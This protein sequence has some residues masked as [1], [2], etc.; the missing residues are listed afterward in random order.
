[1]LYLA[2]T[3]SYAFVNHEKRPAQWISSSLKHVSSSRKFHIIHQ[4]SGNTFASTT[5]TTTKLFDSKKS[6][7]FEGNKGKEAMNLERNDKLNGISDKDI[8]E[9]YD[10]IIIGSGIGGLSAACLLT[11]YGYSVLVLESHYKPGGCAHAF[12]V[13]GFKFDAGPSLWNGMS[14]LP[15]N[16]L[17]EILNLV[18]EGDSISYAKYDGWQMY[19]PDGSFK[20]TVG[21]GDFEKILQNFGDSENVLTEWQQLLQLVKPYQDLADAVPPLCLRSDPLVI[22][23]LLP[24]LPKLIKGIPYASQIEKDFKSLSDRVVKDSFLN[25]WL[26]FLSFALSGLPADATITAAVVYTMRD[27]H[28]QRAA[29]DYP[30]GG[31]GAVVDALI[32]GMENK[33]Q[34][35][36]GSGNGN[37]KGQGRLLLNSHV[38]RILIEEEDSSSGIQWPWSTTTTTTT[39]S[40]PSDSGSS[41]GN[42]VVDRSRSSNSNSNSSSRRG[43]RKPLEA[44]GVELRKNKRKIYAKR[45]VI[46]NASYWDTMK[47]LPDICMSSG[48]LQEELDKVPRTNSFVHLHL[49]INGEGLQGLESHYTVINQWEKIDA[50]QNHVIISIPTV[51]D[52]SLAPPGCHVIHAYAAANE[53]FEV[54]EKDHVNDDDDDKTGV[55]QGS[56]PPPTSSKTIPKKM[57]RQA[58]EKLK[59]ERC[60]FLWQAIER[61]IP[62]VRQRVVVN[63]SASPLTHARFNRRYKGTF[64]PAYRAGIDKFPYPKD[65]NIK[66]LLCCGDSIFPGIGVP[67]VAVSGANAASSSVSVFKQLEMLQRRKQNM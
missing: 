65:L 28:Q 4:C 20:F 45:S 30:I 38:E 7:A 50:P 39:M 26:N 21:E 43:A 6:A 47:L 42:G 56:T 41:E 19:T 52:P 17:R 13:D 37:G 51:L 24:H 63:Q 36:L 58:Y 3:T 44:V 1:M 35:G 59:E 14:T 2:S 46:T 49:G 64:G 55:L 23:T 40:P 57:S 10:Y 5:A 67:A 12:E 61:F 62:D 34:I 29:L 11:F 27:L 66:N 15:Y 32:R 9:E 60:E 8:N 48:N 22:L 16:P 54:W 25:N 18:G 31:S 53:P 33:K